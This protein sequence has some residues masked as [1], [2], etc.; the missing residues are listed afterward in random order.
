MVLDCQARI[1]RLLSTGVQ[2]LN[3]GKLRGALSVRAA[4]QGQSV[5]VHTRR[6][7]PGVHL[8]PHTPPGAE[9]AR[10]CALRG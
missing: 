4:W 7:L 3:Q 5:A 2:A 8:H 6:P 9:K 10:A 1:P